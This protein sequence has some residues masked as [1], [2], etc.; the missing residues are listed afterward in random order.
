[1]HILG[2]DYS[3]AQIKYEQWAGLY[4]DN[5]QMLYVNRGIGMVGPPIRISI[6]PE[7][8]VFTLVRQ[9]NRG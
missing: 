1:M 2:K 9:E 3:F 8:T 5:N 6:E 4:S 7:I